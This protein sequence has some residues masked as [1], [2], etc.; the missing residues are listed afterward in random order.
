MKEDKGTE[1]NKFMYMYKTYTQ[2][3]V[4]DSQRE[5]GVG[6]GGQRGDKWWQK[7][8]AWGDGCMIQCVEYVYRVVHLKP[9][10]Q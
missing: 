5:K 6:V 8:T 2:T 4:G 3:T 7:E 1:Q 9:V 10:S